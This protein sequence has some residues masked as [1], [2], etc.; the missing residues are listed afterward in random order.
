M[1][2]PP[3]ADGKTVS[4]DQ[5][6]PVAVTLT[7]SDTDGDT[8]TYAITGNPTHGT[9]T[10]TGANRTYTPTAGYS[11]GDSFT[12]KTNDGQ[13]DSANATVS[14]TV[15]AKPTG[16]PTAPLADTTVTAN[17]KS[18]SATFTAPAVTTSGD[19][20]LILAYIAADGP[21]APTQKVL[22]VSGGGLTWSL[23]A[24]SNATWGT[25]EVWQ[26]YAPTKVSGLVVK[27]KLAYS[28]DGSITVAAYSG[29]GSKAGQV[30]T[31]ARIDKLPSAKVKN[32]ACGSLV[33]AVGHDWTNSNLVTPTS[34]Q[35]LISSFVDKRVHDAFWVQKV[36]APTAVGG[37]AV[38]VSGSLPKS[39]RWT[40][41]AIEIPA[42]PPAG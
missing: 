17:I 10:G 22:S 5:D 29:A 35:S 28:F 2:H 24:R 19:K 34:G 27:A 3:T 42:A 41:A 31:A 4:T 25:T 1:N 16:C 8:L 39:D 36:N 23:A 38:T 26:A 9:L 15:K 32:V 12:Y 33:V 30:A 14:I 37:S 18:P 7:G 13:A 11:G 21:A 6:T 20:R 40:L